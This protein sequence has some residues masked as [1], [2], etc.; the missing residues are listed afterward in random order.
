MASVIDI[1][2]GRYWDRPLS[3]V[4]GCTPVS[5]A[6]DNCWLRSIDRIYRPENLRTVTPR[7]DRLDIPLTVKK[8][9]VWAI[10][11]DLFHPV[12]SDTFIDHAWAV[13]LLSPRHTFL[14]LTKRVERMAEYLTSPGRYER[15]VREADIIKN[16]YPRYNLGSIGISDPAKHPAKWIWPG[17]TIENQKWADVRLP[18]LMRVPAAHRF[19]SMEPTLGSVEASKWLHPRQSRNRDGYGGDEGPGW[20]TDFSKVDLVILGGESGPKARPMNP[21]WAREVR[22]ECHTYDVPFFFKQWGEWL[23]KSQQGTDTKIP[24][25]FYRVG[26]AKAGRILDGRTHDDLPWHKSIATR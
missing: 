14:V 23:H 19:V 17:T 16:A 4:D 18:F 26:K 2:V 12:V 3:L 15:I 8:P 1:S 9:T 20:R 21:D 5:E 22:D 24:D 11:S 13:M 25:G 7:P 10:W 6:C